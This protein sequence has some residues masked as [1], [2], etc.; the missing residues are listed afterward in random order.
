MIPRSDLETSLV[1]APEIV[2]KEIG[3][4]KA[5]ANISTAEALLAKG[6]PTRETMDAWGA[7]VEVIT[8]EIR[9]IEKARDFFLA[10]IKEAKQAVEAARKKQSA[11]FDPAI[12]FLSEIKKRLAG[13]YGSF[14]LQVQAEDKAT[15]EAFAEE[16]AKNVAADSSSD[17]MA[18]VNADE[19]LSTPINVPRSVAKTATG[20]TFV[21]TIQRVRIVKPGLVP[22][23]YCKLDEEKLLADYKSGLITEVPGVEFYQEA[24]TVVR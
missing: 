22:R 4:F 21:R 11:Y 10:P 24:I 13:V 7:E 17:F 5:S 12:N 6:T 2:A 8:K 14:V 3:D 18:D 15:Y 20:S 1:V 16:T 23:E 19:V 9:R